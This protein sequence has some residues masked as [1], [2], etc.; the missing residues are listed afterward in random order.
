MH[1]KGSILPSFKKEFHDEPFQPFLSRSS[2]TISSSKMAPDPLLS[3][4]FYKAPPDC[5]KSVPTAT[6]TEVSLEETNSDEKNLEKTVHP[7]PLSNKNL[8]ERAKKC[9]FL[10]GLL[11]STI[12]DNDL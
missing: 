6:S 4:L 5:S 1:H 3:F 12:L 2:S 9:E 10:Q 11:L 8:M 7:S